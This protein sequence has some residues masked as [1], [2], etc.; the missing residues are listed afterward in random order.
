M[1]GGCCY[2]LSLIP[3]IICLGRFRIACRYTFDRVRI[4]RLEGNYFSYAPLLCYDFHVVRISN[5][6]SHR[7]TN[8]IVNYV[9][10]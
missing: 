5:T 6:H 1:G 9:S 2:G 8:K 3:S 10:N 4:L 7:S